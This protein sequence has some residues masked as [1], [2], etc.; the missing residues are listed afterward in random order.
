MERHL[1]L[2]GPPR[3]TVRA[4]RLAHAAPHP[5]LA[6]GARLGRAVLDLLL[7]PHCPACDAP[8]DRPG[9]LCAGCFGTLAFVTEPCCDGCGTPF[10]ASALGGREHR[11]DACRDAPPAWNRA[12]AA[13]CYDDAS[14]GLVLA[15]KYGD[16]TENAAM[17]A[18]HMARAG[19][20][21]LAQAELLVPVPLHRWRLLSRRYNQAALLA[22]A[23]ARSPAGR[24]AGVRTLPDALARPRA[25][26]RLAGLGALER[27]AALEGAIVVRP[28]RRAEV[29]GRRIVLVDDVL[30]TGATA[31]ACTRALL[32]AGALRVDLLVA[33][34]AISS[35]REPAPDSSDEPD[36]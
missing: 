19:R 23:L 30:T 36:A 21:L 29:A 9:S 18:A 16:R 4:S 12:R 28:H 7:P 3:S 31:R 26:T 24:A 15:L 13:L 34:R 20:T 32:G 33:A 11:C 2:P 1:V 27:A 10:A 25:T 22:R 35:P 14:R 8:V 5:M 6:L 17:L